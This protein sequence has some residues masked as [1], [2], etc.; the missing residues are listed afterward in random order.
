MRIQ[1]ALNTRTY[2]K[3]VISLARYPGKFGV[4][5]HNTMIAHHNLD[6]EYIAC[7]TDNLQESI[8]IIRTNDITGCSVS[9]PFKIEV[10]Q[11]LDQIDESALAVGA[12]NTIVNRDRVLVGYNTDLNGAH[13]ALTQ[14]H[15]KI[16][17]LGNGGMSRAFQAA[18]T[19]PYVLITRS[20]WHNLI[21]EK[22]D[23]IINATPIGMLDDSSPVDSYS[24]SLAIDSV[25]KMS[26]FVRLSKNSING[27]DI[28]LRQ[29]AAQYK[30]YFDKDADISI[31]QSSIK[32]MY[33]Q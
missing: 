13:W 33:D 24:H 22:F 2:N 28:S 17:L 6:A 16:A 26:K 3:L 12:V 32:E 7:S 27:I 23:T 14:A 10:M 11:Y 1:D 5:V 31:M 8:S 25:V 4:R 21:S 19:V 18:I 9:M 29:A 30:L 15:G 20:N